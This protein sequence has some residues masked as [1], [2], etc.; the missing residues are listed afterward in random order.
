MRNRTAEAENKH[1]IGGN[2]LDALSR[3]LLIATAGVIVGSLLGTAHVAAFGF[4]VLGLSAAAGVGL[5]VGAAMCKNA[6]RNWND[7]EPEEVRQTAEILCEIADLPPVV[8]EADFSMPAE[9]R[10]GFVELVDRQRERQT[11][12]CV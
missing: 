7:P 5:S 6:G 8:L 10:A 1:T 11:G 4:W 2:I 9:R 12:K 3:G